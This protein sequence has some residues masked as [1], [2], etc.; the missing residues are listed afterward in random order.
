MSVLTTHGTELCGLLEICIVKNNSGTL[1]AEFHQNWLQILPA[2]RPDDPTDSLTA[3]EIDLAD[4]FVCDESV[5][6]GGSVR[7]G[8][9]DTVDYSG[10]HTSFFERFN[11]TVMRH[12]AL[13]GSFDHDG[14][15]CSYGHAHCTGWKNDCTVPPKMIC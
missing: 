12:R 7:P 13:L 15:S 11:E 10:R 2:Q 3:N 9:L 5:C 6:D 1:A 8:D 14:T 4:C